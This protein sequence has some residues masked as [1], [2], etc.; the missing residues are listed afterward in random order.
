MYLSEQQVKEITRGTLDIT[1]ENGVYYFYRFSKWQMEVYKNTKADFFK[2]SQATSSVNFDF[3]TDADKFGFDFQVTSGSSRDFYYFDIY[4][5]GVLTK[6]CGESPM[7]IKKGRIDV[8]LP[9]GEHRVTVWFPN[10]ACAMISNISVTDGAAVRPVAYDTKMICWGDSITQGYDA[11]FPSLSYANRLAQH[12]NAYMI[13]QAIGGERFAPHILDKDMGFKPDI[14]TIAYG[15]NDWSGLQRDAFFA[16][17]DGFL[18]GVAQMYPDA[19]IFVITPL[20]RGDKDK[21]TKFGSYYEAV[22]YIADKAAALGLNVID[23]Y[24]LTPHYYEFYSDKRLHPND[25]GY[26][27]YTRN[28]IPKI[29]EKL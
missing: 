9:E 2:K 22:K 21:I 14:I 24:D 29:E 23:G 16:G 17:T 20:W 1:C 27:E 19:K 26:G 25:L 18:E 4:V 28:L 15:T 12:F 13:N 7:W 5:D 6:H 8:D 10:L 11:I 3:V